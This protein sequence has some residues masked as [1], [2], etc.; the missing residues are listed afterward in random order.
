M[1][2]LPF[3]AHLSRQSAFACLFVFVLVFSG[4]G[5]PTAGST[6]AAASGKAKQQPAVPILAAEVQRRDLPVELT[7]IGVVEAI[8]TVTV[9]P[10]VDGQ[11]QSVH[12]KDGD[13]VQQGQ[14]LFT[15]DERPF[16]AALNQA[17]ANLSA[18]SAKSNQATADNQRYASLIKT[19]AVTHEE[20]DAKRA[21][22]ESLAAQLQADQAAVEMARLKVDYCGIKSPLAGRAGQVLVDAGNTV[23]TNETEMVVINQLQPIDVAFSIPETQLP[24][25]RA[26]QAAGQPE[27]AAMPSGQTG[28]PSLGRLTFIDNQVDPQ[29]GTIKLR[30]TFPNGDR[31]LWPGQFVQVKLVLATERGVLIVPSQAVQTG[32]QGSFIY[33]IQPDQTVEYRPVATERYGELLNMIRKGAQAGERIV[34]DG[35]LRLTP[36]ARVEIKT[37]LDADAAT[38]PTAAQAPAGAAR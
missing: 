12:I 24:A 6:P 1:P 26:A 8:H 29:T 34:L 38:S 10:Q 25:V 20:T 11:L 28:E 9:K 31:R 3:A 27:C 5:K 37:S 13:N 14:L 16:T 4:C 21:A 18:D 19:G 30:A 32:Q 36:G 17:R 33:V 7:A 22:A 35:Q 2:R 23:K 15:I